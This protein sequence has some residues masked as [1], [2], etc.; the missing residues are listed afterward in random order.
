MKRVLYGVL[1]AGLA[2]G[3]AGCTGG[4]G[5]VWPTNPGGPAAGTQVQVL[6][7]SG[8]TSA[9][10]SQVVSSQMSNAIGQGIGAVACPMIPNFTLGGITAPTMASVRFG[11]KSKDK[12][13][14][15]SAGVSSI[16]DVAKTGDFYKFE[17]S[18]KTTGTEYSSSG[19]SSSSP[20]CSVRSS[21]NSNS[22]AV[23]MV[24]SYVWYVKYQD[25]SGNVLPVTSDSTTWYSV[26]G[27]VDSVQFYGAW[28][29][30]ETSKDGKFNFQN[31]GAF[32]SSTAPWMFQQLSSSTLPTKV[33]GSSTYASSGTF[34]GNAVSGLAFKFEIG[35]SDGF[36]SYPKTSPYIPTGYYKISTASGY[37]LF[38][39]DGQM[40][41]V[42]SNG[43][44]YDSYYVMTSTF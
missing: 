30:T 23:D 14:A 44:P 37:I 43:Y 19:S 15:Q 13:S 31:T 9:L 18:Y 42:T 1:A 32:G 36:M 8:M 25:A 17:Y 21:T 34:D 26:T 12:A 22:T 6:G 40:H 2:L 28:T 39:F 41:K 16:K 3:F 11:S 35:G 38:T 27:T 29:F 5:G 33:M 7:E 10:Q 20:A 24:W 4:N